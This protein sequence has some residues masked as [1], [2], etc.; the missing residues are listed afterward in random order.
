MASSTLRRYALPAL[1]A[2]SALSLAACSTAESDNT[3]TSPETPADTPTAETSKAAELDPALQDGGTVRED[4]VEMMADWF[5][6][7]ETAPH[8]ELTAMASD[9][10]GEVTNNY[11]GEL[12]WQDR[13]HDLSGRQSPQVPVS[14]PVFDT[15]V[16]SLDD[17]DGAWQFMGVGI[18]LAH[19]DVA[20]FTEGIGFSLENSAAPKLPGMVMTSEDEDHYYLTALLDMAVVSIPSEQALAQFN[21]DLMNPIAFWRSTIA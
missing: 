20:D 2:A 13:N 21:T 10:T 19:E 5:I 1:L 16:A 18:R 15:T 12:T 7:K 11:R 6:D 9:W 8:P 3:D 4:A 17:P 14:Y